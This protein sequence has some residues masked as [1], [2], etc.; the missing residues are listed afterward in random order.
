MCTCMYK[1]RYVYLYPTFKN[2]LHGGSASALCVNKMDVDMLL[3][4][5][6]SRVLFL[7]SMPAGSAGA[8]CCGLLP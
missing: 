3:S 6:Q 7:L 5:S 1:I 4:P 2:S 8:A